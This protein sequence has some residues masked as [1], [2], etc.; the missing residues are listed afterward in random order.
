MAPMKWGA[1]TFSG[2]SVHPALPALVVRDG[3]E[4]LPPPSAVSAHSITL[5]LPDPGS[6]GFDWITSPARPRR[7]PPHPVPLLGKRR[8]NPWCPVYRGTSVLALPLGGLEVYCF[9]DP[10][11]FL[12]W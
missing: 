5:G 11:V 2:V 3:Q 6:A 1:I 4:D 7:L 8:P 10:D 12:E 9:V